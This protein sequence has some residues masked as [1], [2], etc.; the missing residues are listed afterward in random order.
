MRRPR[1]CIDMNSTSFKAIKEVSQESGVPFSRLLS[2]AADLWVSR[3]RKDAQPDRDAQTP[4]D[5]SKQQGGVML[6]QPT[7]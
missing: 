3:Y 7:Y 2:K 6:C 5:S 4:N 1:T